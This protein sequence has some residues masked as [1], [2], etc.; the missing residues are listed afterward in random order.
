MRKWVSFRVPSVCADVLVT[1]I[2][3]GAS[4][5]ADDYLLAPNSDSPPGA[6]WVYQ[7]D[8]AT[9]RRCWYLTEAERA[10]VAHHDAE[11]QHRLTPTER[12]ALFEEFLRWQQQQKPRPH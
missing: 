4:V 1:T 12:D 8:R 9:N 11:P 7:T 5:R 3:L 10:P 2:A 6:R